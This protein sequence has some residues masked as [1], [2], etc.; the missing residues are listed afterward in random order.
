MV[1]QSGIHRQA[2]EVEPDGLGHVTD[3]LDHRV[4]GELA[5]RHMRRTVPV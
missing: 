3:H 1:P 2:G 5:C 4:R